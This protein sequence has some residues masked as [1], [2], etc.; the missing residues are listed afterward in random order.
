LILHGFKKKRI[1]FTSD[2]KE[3]RKKMEPLT[4]ANLQGFSAQIAEKKRIADIEYYVAQIYKEVKNAATINIQPRIQV[5]VVNGQFKV[6]DNMPDIMARLRTL[7]PDSDIGVG[8]LSNGINP[9]TGLECMY[10]FI[11]IDWS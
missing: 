7:F 11:V 8:S 1:I 4:R 6:K 3:K 10:D 2:Q 5:P 9:R